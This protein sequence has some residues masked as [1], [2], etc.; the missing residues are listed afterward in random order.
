MK[1]LYG[2]HSCI[3]HSCI[4][5]IFNASIIE[6]QSINT[7]LFDKISF[8][9]FFGKFMKWCDEPPRTSH[10]PEPHSWEPGTK[11]SQRNRNPWKAQKVR[12]GTIEV[13][14]MRKC[15]EANL[16]WYFPQLVRKC[17]VAVLEIGFRCNAQAIVCLLYFENPLILL[18]APCP[19]GALYLILVIRVSTVI[20]G[21]QICSFT[22]FT[23]L[24]VMWISK[25]TSLT[26]PVCQ[27]PRI[28]F[29]IVQTPIPS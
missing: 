10:P 27:L 22:E 25:S 20:L 28:K 4:L 9:L 16:L 21:V 13:E 19:E 1:R 2:P 11:I 15:F 5:S 7:D 23:E 8:S 18:L 29:T 12:V 3:H 26:L 24:Q 17:L 14:S 6:Q